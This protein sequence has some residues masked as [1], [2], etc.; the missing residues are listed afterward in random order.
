[1]SDLKMCMLNTVEPH[2]NEDLVTMKI[3]LLYRGKKT[4]KYKKLGPAKLP[5]YKRVSLYLTSL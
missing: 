3:T 1:M 4:K 2:Y 5:C